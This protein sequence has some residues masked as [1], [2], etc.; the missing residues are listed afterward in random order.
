MLSEVIK[1]Y[2]RS[3]DSLQISAS[4]CHAEHERANL[5]KPI[6]SIGRV[7]SCSSEVYKQVY[8]LVLLSQ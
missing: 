6:I 3:P 2:L 8:V 5:F 7:A 1:E 4:L